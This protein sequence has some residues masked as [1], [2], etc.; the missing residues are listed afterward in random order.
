MPHVEVQTLPNLE[1][2]S[3]QLVNC[4]HKEMTWCPRQDPTQ[5]IMREFE[6]LKSLLVILF[7]TVLSF[8]FMLVH[9]VP[10]KLYANNMGFRAVLVP[11]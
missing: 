10:S 2:E 1:V 8:T 5:N 3:S 9:F 4:L 7:R 6:S 11:L